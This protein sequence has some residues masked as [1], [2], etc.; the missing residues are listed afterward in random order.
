MHYAI[1]IRRVIA[2]DIATGYELDDEE[3]G[4]PF[5]YVKKCLFLLV[6][7]TGSGVNPASHPMDN[8]GYFLRIEAAAG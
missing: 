4:V 3:I 8:R 6:V 5:A 2:V 1:F 7:H